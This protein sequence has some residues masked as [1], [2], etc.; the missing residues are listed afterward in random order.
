MP[1][2]MQQFNGI[3]DTV[4]ALDE[5]YLLHCGRASFLFPSRSWK[6]P[7][8]MRHLKADMK[9]KALENSQW[10]TIMLRA[11]NI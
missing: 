9:Q 5:G 10:G 7:H 3:L 4:K 8:H 2:A 6:R 1:T 11:V